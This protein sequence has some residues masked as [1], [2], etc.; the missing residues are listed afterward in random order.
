[1]PKDRPLRE[2]DLDGDP[3]RQFERWFEE[4]VAAGVGQPDAAALATA[5]ADARPSV[6]MVLVKDRR[7]DGF[8]FFTSHHSRKG[9]ELAENPRAALLF[10]WEPEGRQIRLEG[11]VHRLDASVTAAYV[12]SRPRRSQLSA[13]ASPQSEVVA[14]RAELE[15]RVAELAAAHDGE[16]LPMPEHWGGF[17]LVP[18]Q[19]E[20][21][22]H[23]SDRLHDRLVYLPE[24]GGGWRIQRLG[25]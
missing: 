7:A 10:H 15:R 1:M 17:A 8:R 11:S 16:E 22:Q 14:G 9:R 25:P 2:T 21:W 4:A 20:F 3:L 6:R 5:A 23:G 12:R 18:E 13:L 24:P 19:Y